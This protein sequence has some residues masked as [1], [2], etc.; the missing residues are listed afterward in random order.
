VILVDE[1]LALLASRAVR[2]PRSPVAYR[3]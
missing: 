2:R 1:T 3:R